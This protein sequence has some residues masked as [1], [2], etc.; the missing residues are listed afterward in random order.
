VNCS[1]RAIQ[2]FFDSS[3][4]FVRQSEAFYWVTLAHSSTQQNLISAR[5]C[6]ALSQSLL[7]HCQSNFPSN[8]GKSHMSFESA[9]AS[10]HE[11]IVCEAAGSPNRSMILEKAHDR[12]KQSSYPQLRR[13]A[14]EFHEGVLI[15]RG[16]VGSYFIK[17]LA[18][19]LV[20]DCVGVEEVSNRLEVRYP[21]VSC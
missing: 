8:H 20:A 1:R 7:H 10:I 2:A 12:L 6:I 18:H 15:L 16:I 13:I 21:A 3:V 17:Q 9:S 14:C 4:A 19:V 5:F 11:S